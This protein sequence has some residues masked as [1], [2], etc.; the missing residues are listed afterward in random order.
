VSVTNK[1]T[2][3][4]NIRVRYPANFRLPLNSKELT[5]DTLQGYDLSL[6][7]DAISIR[8]KYRYPVKIPVLMLDTIARTYSFI[9]KAGQEVYVESRFPAASP[10]Y[11]QVFIIGN[12]DT[13]VLKR[14][15]KIFKKE[16]KLL[17][18]CSWNY[19]IREQQ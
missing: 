9:L 18:G 14:H 16:P 2:T 17:P 1:S 11:G 6:T 8:D 4:K 13:V 10:T 3:D 19:T 7:G 5:N 15:G 12:T